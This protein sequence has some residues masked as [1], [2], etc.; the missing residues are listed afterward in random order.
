MASFK[1]ELQGNTD[2]LKIF[3]IFLREC[4]ENWRHNT[5]IKFQEKIIL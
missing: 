3:S 4:L 5:F 1:Y 2:N